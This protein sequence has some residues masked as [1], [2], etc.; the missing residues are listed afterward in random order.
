[1]GDTAYCDTKIVDGELHVKGDICAIDGWL[2]TGDLVEQD[3]GIYWYY[4]RV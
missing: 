4:G 2:A 3:D 1:M